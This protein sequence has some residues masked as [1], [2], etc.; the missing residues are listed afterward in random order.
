MLHSEVSITRAQ[1]RGR[2]SFTSGQDWCGG[3]LALH[4]SRPRASQ[5]LNL[6]PGLPSA[7]ICANYICTK[8]RTCVD[9]FGVVPGQTCSEPSAHHVYPDRQLQSF[10]A[11]T[12]GPSPETYLIRDVLPSIPPWVQP[13]TLRQCSL[14]E[15]ALHSPKWPDI[16]RVK[17]AKRE[18]R[19]PS[20]CLTSSACP[21][22]GVDK[23][24][25]DASLTSPIL[26]VVACLVW[27]AHVWPPHATFSSLFL[28]RSHLD[29]AAF[30]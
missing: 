8:G 6:L 29:G 25:H 1:H 24:I 16:L 7:S 19:R 9:R 23:T 28:F 11:F 2:L 3:R 17:R 10:R 22:S 15:D 18:D 5:N 14:S 12:Q 21:C 26:E 30:T 13:G 4:R 27:R 20:I